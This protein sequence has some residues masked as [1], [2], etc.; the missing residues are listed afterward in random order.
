MSVVLLSLLVIALFALV[1]LAVAFFWGGESRRL[2][3]DEPVLSEK[4]QIPHNE[5]QE[6]AGKIL[7]SSVHPWWSPLHG[8]SIAAFL[9]PGLYGLAIG[10][11]E[12]VAPLTVLKWLESFQTI[13]DFTSLFIPSIDR[14]NVDLALFPVKAKLV[15]HVFAITF[16][17]SAYWGIP[18]VI[19]TLAFPRRG[20]CA[21]YLPGR[22]KLTFVEAVDRWWIV[23]VPM[24]FITLMLVYFIY[25]GMDIDPWE[26][27]GRRRYTP[28]NNPV[29]LWLI[30]VL[31]P[32]VF[33]C[34]S[35][36]VE[37]MKGL[38]LKNFGDKL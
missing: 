33:F 37:L 14:A 23:F 10:L 8:Y 4:N 11:V 7:T 32:T 31:W 20:V 24:F 22:M 19:R 28:H 25:W 3:N 5:A 29:I 17:I 35:I 9:A 15:S 12:L 1:T 21:E 2:E 26:R 6:T 30:G 27:V 38:L 16:W 18:C 36:N 13:V 34:I